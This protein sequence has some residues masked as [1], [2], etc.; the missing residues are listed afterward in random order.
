VIAS[1][2]R[3]NPFRQFSSNHRIIP[4]TRVAVTGVLDVAM[5]ILPRPDDG[6]RYP[7]DPRG[8]ANGPIAFLPAKELAAEV[9]EVKE[10]GND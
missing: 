1:T 5:S 6:C 2:E 9:A 10:F 8:Q 4:C 3:F 7:N